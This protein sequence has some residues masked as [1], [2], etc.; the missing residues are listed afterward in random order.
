MTIV[1]VAADV[2]DSGL[3]VEQGPTLY[4]PYLQTNTPL[5]R[6]SLV[7]RTERDPLSVANA[8]RAAIWTID[9]L[10]PVDRTGRLDDV[11]VEGTSE[12]RFRTVLLAAFAAI[13]LALALVGIYGVSAAAVKARTWEVGVRLAL[14]A[15]PRAVVWGMLRESG[16]RVLAGAA[17]GLAAFL[18]LSRLGAGLLYGTSFGNPTVLGASAA[19]LGTASFAVIYGQARRLARVLPASALRDQSGT[20]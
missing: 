13:G 20:R 17:A 4:S 2:M 5:A 1:G 8:V 15:S 3:G 6:V 9:P 10:Q 12:Q 7:V 14:G 16:T 11:L 19:L 18:A